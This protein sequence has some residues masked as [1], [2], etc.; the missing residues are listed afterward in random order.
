MKILLHVHDQQAKDCDVPPTRVTE[1]KFAK[2]QGICTTLSYVAFADHES[3]IGDAMPIQNTAIDASH[4]FA[5]PVFWSVCCS[6]RA[7]VFPGS[8]RLIGDALR[9]Q[10]IPC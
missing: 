5:D 4:L 3:I 8:E 2:D 9:I 1:L 7:A 10:R 6:L